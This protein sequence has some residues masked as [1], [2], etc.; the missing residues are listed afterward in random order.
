VYAIEVHLFYQLL[1]FQGIGDLTEYFVEQAHQDG[2]ND[3]RTKTNKDRV[4]VA[5]IQ[6]NWEHK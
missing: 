6:S 4:V 1:W 2:I 5:V 3:R